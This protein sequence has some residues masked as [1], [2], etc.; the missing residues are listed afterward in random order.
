M[1]KDSFAHS[2]ATKPRYRFP[3]LPPRLMRSLLV[4]A[5]GARVAVQSLQ[6]AYHRRENMVSRYYPRD[7]SVDLC[8]SAGT[9]GERHRGQQRGRGGRKQH[10]RA[11]RAG[12]AMPQCPDKLPEHLL[13]ILDLALHHP[14]AGR[15]D[16]WFSKSVT[17]ERA[18]CGVSCSAPAGRKRREPRAPT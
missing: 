13:L 11:P 12:L 15:N 6:A 9:V 10:A 3:Q 2:W 5:K 7:V 18:G 14:A 4:R 1:T 16:G 8:L 17:T